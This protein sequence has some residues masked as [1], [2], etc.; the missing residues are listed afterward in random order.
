MVDDWMPPKTPGLG[1]GYLWKLR[2]TAHRR[3][4]VHGIESENL[5]EVFEMVQ[6]I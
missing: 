3:W 2:V 6:C 1:E 4:I 5:F